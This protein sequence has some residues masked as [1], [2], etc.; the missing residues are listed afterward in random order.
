MK[1]ILL[2]LAAWLLLVSCNQIDTTTSSTDI[3]NPDARYLYFYGATCPHCQELNRQLEE[4][5]YISK[6]SVEKRE[7]YFNT[8]NQQSFSDVWDKL[9]LSDRDRSVPFVLDKTTG[10]YVTGVT[11]AFA[12]LTS[13]IISNDSDSVDE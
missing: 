13:N 5:D 3:I 6:I 2:F 11:D 12:M 1:K 9:G 7:I 8:V 4:G 10:E